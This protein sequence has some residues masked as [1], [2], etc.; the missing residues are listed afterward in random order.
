MSGR[1]DPVAFVADMVQA[2]G[3]IL[4][5]TSGLSDPDVLDPEGPT[6]AAVL[7]LLVVIGEAAKHVPDDIRSRDPDL[8]WAAFA[9]L[10]DKVVHYYFGLSDAAIIG[11]VRGELPSDL[12]RLRALLADLE[13][14]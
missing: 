2:A 9:G 1:S 11:A 12:A 5:F 3:R 8:P 7:H 6:R 4:A 10:R 13:A 14:D